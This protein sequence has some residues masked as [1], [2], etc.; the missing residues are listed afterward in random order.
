MSRIKLKIFSAWDSSPF[1]RA[2]SLQ[3]SVDAWTDDN[4]NFQIL[5]SDITMG[6]ENEVM[7]TIKYYESIK[8]DL[9]LEKEIKL[10]V[11]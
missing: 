11:I 3:K 8:R 6:G 9:L 10:Q 7:M 5:D 2:R 1:S 4:P